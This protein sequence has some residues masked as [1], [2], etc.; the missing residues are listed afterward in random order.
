MG[1]GVQIDYHQAA[2]SRL[3]T[4]SWAMA[5]TT[6]KKKELILKK[7]IRILLNIQKGTTLNSRRN[8][9]S[10]IRTSNETTTNQPVLILNPSLPAPVSPSIVNMSNTFK[11]SSDTSKTL[12]LGLGFAHH[13]SLKNHLSDIIS[14]INYSLSRSLCPELAL[15]AKYEIKPILSNYDNGNSF[16][17][18]N[19]KV[20]RELAVNN[21]YTMQSDKGNNIV[22]IDKPDYDRH[23]FELLNDSNIYTP[24][25][26]NPTN[27]IVA[28]LKRTV[29]TCTK[30]TKKDKA[31]LVPFAQNLA[32]F[33]ALLK[34]HKNPI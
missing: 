20:I 8:Q 17:N 13:V 31:N 21:V 2:W 9:P 25:K 10:T 11:L 15:Q 14:G 18:H 28:T 24:I 19:L 12:Q 6:A 1:R 32:N 3:D 5:H 16:S 4:V 34:I 23:L 30:L 7:K 22:I 29:N 27:K 26:N 33:Y